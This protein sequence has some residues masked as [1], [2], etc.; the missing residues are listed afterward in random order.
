MYFIPSPVTDNSLF[1]AVPIVCVC[2]CVC[3]CVCVCVVLASNSVVKFVVI[4]YNSFA[5]ILLRKK[6]RKL[7][8]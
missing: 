6:D 1:F 8:T 3:A 5:A 2:V 4:L 7:I